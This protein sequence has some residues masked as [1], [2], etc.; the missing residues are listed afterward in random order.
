MPKK[1]NYECAQASAAARKYEVTNRP[2]IGKT[3]Q[4]CIRL[5]FL[6]QQTS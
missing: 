6:I 2:N 5:S 1:A 4:V 3:S